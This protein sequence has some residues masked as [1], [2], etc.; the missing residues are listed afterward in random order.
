MQD[1][2]RK[3]LFNY[4]QR[5]IHNNQQWWDLGQSHA[6]HAGYWDETT[7]SLHEALLRENHILAEIAQIKPEDHVLDVGCGIGGSALFLHSHYKCQVTG[8]D[9]SESMIQRA[10]QDNDPSLEFKV[11]DFNDINFPDQSFDVIWVLESLCHAADKS[12][13]LNNAW[14]LLKSSGRLILADGFLAKENLSEAEKRSLSNSEQ[15]FG[16]SFYETKAKFLTDLQKQGFTNIK[17]QDASKNILPSARR[18][19]YL[20]FPLIAWSKLGEYLGW[21]YAERTEDFKG[22][23]FQYKPLKEGLSLYLIIYAEKPSD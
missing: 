13:F 22:Y 10:R 19:Y 7:N 5:C 17:V 4:Y 3:K 18:L 15:N 8:I 9:L 11:M 23:Y 14:R 21:S 2:E 6:I 16:A 1:D 20:S 12:A